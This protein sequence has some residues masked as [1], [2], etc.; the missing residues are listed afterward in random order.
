M[1]RKSPTALV[2]FALFAVGSAVAAPLPDEAALEEVLEL[3]DAL[4][5]GTQDDALRQLPRFRPLCDADGYPLVG[6]VIRKGP[7]TQPSW[8]CEQVRTRESK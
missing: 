1:K 3:R 7:S 2:P 5:A 8:F 4:S 6:N